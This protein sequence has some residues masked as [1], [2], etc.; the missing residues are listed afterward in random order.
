MYAEYKGGRA[1]TPDEFREQMPFIKEILEA[2]GIRYYEHVNWNRLD[3]IGTLATQWAE[4]SGFDKITVVSGD[5]DLTQLTTEKTQQFEDF[6]L[7]ALQS[8]E[9]YLAGLSIWEL[10]INNWTIHRFKALMGDKSDN[11]PGVTKVGEKTN[12]QIITWA[13]GR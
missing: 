6:K 3:I 5:R 1:K 2:Q 8:L 11:I 7:K 4:K 9:T 10:R 13:W 12:Y